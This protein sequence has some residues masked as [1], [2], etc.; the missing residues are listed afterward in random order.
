M[1][2]ALDESEVN[3]NTEIIYM[4]YTIVVRYWKNFVNIF[5][6]RSVRIQAEV[7]TR[8]IGLTT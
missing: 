4:K 1:L 3:K 7:D 8:S 5:S 6:W 2:S